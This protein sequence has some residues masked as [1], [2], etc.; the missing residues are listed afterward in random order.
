TMPSIA[1]SM[2]KMV[3]SPSQSADVFLTIVAGSGPITVDVYL[4]LQ[5]GSIYYFIGDGGATVTTDVVPFEADKTVSAD[6]MITV[7][8][9]VPLAGVA[10]GTYT[11]FTGFTEPGT[12]QVIGDISIFPFTI[13]P[14][15]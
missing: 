6:E 10:P 3:Y 12:V 4:V 5:V 8:S 9:D 14:I 11:W 15:R 2:D 7:Y 13:S 1:V